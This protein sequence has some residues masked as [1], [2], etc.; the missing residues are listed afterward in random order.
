MSAHVAVPPRVGLFYKL[1]RTYKTSP[2]KSIDVLIHLDAAHPDPMK[3][4]DRTLAITSIGYL[5]S[6]KNM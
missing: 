1:W 6:I 4:L 3:H 2:V 5:S